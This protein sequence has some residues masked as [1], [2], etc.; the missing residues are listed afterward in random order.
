MHY[1]ETNFLTRYP[2]QPK[3]WLRFIDDIF[4]I[5][6]DGEQQLRRFL[7]ALN[8][9]HP[10][11]KFTHAM[12]KN[13]IALLDTIAYRSPTNRIY[14]RICHKPTDQ[15]HY[16][17]YH[18]AHPRNEKESV[19]YGL[20]IRCRRICTEDHYFEEEAKK[21][22]T[23]LKYRKYPTILL[24][25]A[26]EWV[27]NIDRLTSLRPTIKNSKI[28]TSESLPTTIQEIPTSYIY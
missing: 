15:K 9:F 17:H 20:L 7:E 24:N 11:I 16:L 13:E 25:Q 26:I 10:T 6:K 5:W 28:T 2:K 18:S 12:E 22:T 1:L 3:I 23:N 21:Y 4:M 19:P 14:I 8:N 27:R